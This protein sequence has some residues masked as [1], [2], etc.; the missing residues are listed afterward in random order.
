M[1]RNRK[2]T[3]KKIGFSS[4][5]DILNRMKVTTGLGEQLEK[6]KIWEN[7]PELAGH[8][9]APHTQPKGIKE[10]NTLVVECASPVWMHRIS[11][12]KWDLI[13]RVNLMYKKEMVSDVYFV[14]AGDED[15]SEGKPK[16]RKK[17]TPPTP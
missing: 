9:L 5:G 12:I 14:L 13:K 11:F 10:N 8:N 15:L 6:A 4:V 3:T 16:A 1:Q 2:R 7:W 17:K